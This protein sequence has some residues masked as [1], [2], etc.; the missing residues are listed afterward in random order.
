MRT[1]AGECRKWIVF[2]KPAKKKI[3]PR[4]RRMKQSAQWV[5]LAQPWKENIN[6]W[7]FPSLRLG[8]TEMAPDFH[9]P[10]RPCLTLLW[11]PK[12]KGDIRKSA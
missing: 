4:V 9:P 1:R 10:R 8:N 2:L 12:V 6:G 5:E 11:I 7:G 3:S